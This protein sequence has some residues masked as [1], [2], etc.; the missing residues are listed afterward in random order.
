[1][2]GEALL[3][4]FLKTWSLMARLDFRG[5]VSR[6][7]VHRGFLGKGGDSGWHVHWEEAVI[8]AALWWLHTAAPF[9]VLLSGPSRNPQLNNLSGRMDQQDKG[10]PGWG[11]QEKTKSTAR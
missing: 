3:G 9:C 4:V 11:Q 2:R 8:T 10:S 1:M 5:K 7:L 6:H